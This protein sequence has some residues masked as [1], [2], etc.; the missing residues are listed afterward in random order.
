MDR[1]AKAGRFNK[2]MI[3][4]HFKD[5]QA[6]YED[7]L[8]YV[9]LHI[10]NRLNAV[11]KD[12][13]SMRDLLNDIFDTYVGLVMDKPDFVRLVI[14]EM[15]RGGPVLKKLGVVKLADVPFNPI[16]GRIYKYIQKQMK[17]GKIAKMDVFQLMLTIIGQIFTALFLIYMKDFLKGLKLPLDTESL[18][19][20]LLRNR[21]K[22]ILDFTMKTIAI[23]QGGKK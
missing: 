21:K 16:N 14:Y 13:A 12:P 6:I 10:I 19:N 15:M 1:I 7:V 22:F 20:R 9:I 4:Y 23:P 8:K 3:Y 17:E 11:S 5:K 2:A 18:V